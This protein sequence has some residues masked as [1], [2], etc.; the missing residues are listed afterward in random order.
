MGIH[1]G[2][3]IRGFE[4]IGNIENKETREM[5]GWVNAFKDKYTIIKADDS[6]GGKR[7]ATVLS[8]TI[9]K[10]TRVEDWQSYTR[11][12]NLSEIEKVVKLK[13][14]RLYEI[15]RFINQLNKGKLVIYH[16]ITDIQETWIAELSEFMENLDNSSHPDVINFN[17]THEEAEKVDLAKE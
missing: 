2:D 3:Y 1:I 6:Y 15:E 8:D 10:C 7:V 9:A 14:N 11:K 12:I 5:R 13:D 16:P 17:N 4:V